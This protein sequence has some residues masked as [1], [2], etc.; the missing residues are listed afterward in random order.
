MKEHKKAEEFIRRQNAELKKLDR[1]KSNFLNMTSHELRTPMTAMKG[2]TQMLLEE[3]LGPLTIEQKK[4]LNVIL[5][6]TDRLDFLIK[7]ILDTSRLD[8]GNM[9]FSAKSV[10][11]STLIDEVEETMKVSAD[12]KH[13]SLKC[14]VES[15]L[16]KII[17]DAYRI[18][19]VIE[20]LITNAIKFSP[21]GSSVRI[22]VNQLEDQICFEVHDEGIGLDKNH[23][24]HI[25]EAFYQVEGGVD[26][27]FGGT[28]LGL[29]ICRGIVE[30]HGG[31]IWVES[32]GVG[33]G[34]SFK[35]TLPIHSKLSTSKQ[36]SA[37][38]NIFEIETLDSTVEV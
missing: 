18:K 9:K 5:R 3:Q 10:E 12:L 38:S 17:L 22:K 35:F 1:L 25:F 14:D 15:S 7:D 2:H 34:S 26:R 36:T 28:G 37:G 29:T 6:N 24:D 23:M 27:T 8:S 32:D 33:L 11:I 4:S 31:K 19:Q 13:I 21:Q 20:N 30:G 16:P